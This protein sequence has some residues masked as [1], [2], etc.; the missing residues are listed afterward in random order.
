MHKTVKLTIAQVKRLVAEALLLE[1][2]PSPTP[3]PRIP[4]E[5]KQ[6]DSRG[7]AIEAIM[8]VLDKVNAPTDYTL[9]KEDDPPSHHRSIAMMLVD[10][11]RQYSDK[12]V[13]R[14]R[15]KITDNVIRAT[16][17]GRT[18]ATFNLEK[19]EEYARAAIKAA[20]KDDTWGELI[21]E[22]EWSKRVT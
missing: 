6:G 4:S 22:Y 3:P 17:D 15:F 19:F 14:L 7:D 10:K 2:D 12:S 5:I 1:D 20:T 9:N 13:Y 16:A 8:A 11:V 18:I 21:M